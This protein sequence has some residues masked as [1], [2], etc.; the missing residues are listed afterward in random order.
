LITLNVR[1]SHQEF[2]KNFFFN[3]K[4]YFV[5]TLSIVLN[6][7]NN[8]CINFF[9]KFNRC[10]SIDKISQN[11]NLEKSKHVK[12]GDLAGDIAEPPQNVSKQMDR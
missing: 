11:E 9:R 4:G 1:F 6:E 2:K 12:L 8:F 10:Q 5:V 7:L 3:G